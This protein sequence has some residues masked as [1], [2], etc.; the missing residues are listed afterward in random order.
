MHAQQW[1]NPHLNP[2]K[3]GKD[4]QNTICVSSTQRKFTKLPIKIAMCKLS[5]FG[6][7]PSKEA[8]D[9]A[10]KACIALSFLCSSFKFIF[11]RGELSPIQSQIKEQRLAWNRFHI[12]GQTINIRRFW[13][14]AGILPILSKALSKRLQD[15]QINYLYRNLNT[16]TCLIFDY[17]SMC[18]FLDRGPLGDDS[19][20]VS[21]PSKTLYAWAEN[22]QP[23]ISFFNFSSW[24]FC[25]ADVLK[26]SR[27]Y[28]SD[29]W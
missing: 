28:C 7:T 1:L 13:R 25:S 14:K 18:T 23:S 19:P 17:V 15:K 21:S 12:R 6:T 29:R 24:G 26:A 16:C 4:N 22:L 8:L 9:K 5:A 10:S 27:T 2:L 11:Q 20:S 3:V